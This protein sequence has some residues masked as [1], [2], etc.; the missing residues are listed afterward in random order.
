MDNYDS[1]LTSYHKGTNTILM[2][3]KDVLF[4]L[5]KLFFEIKFHK[6][7]CEGINWSFLFT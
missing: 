2:E 4:T 6:K 3:L 1:C 5:N 7:A